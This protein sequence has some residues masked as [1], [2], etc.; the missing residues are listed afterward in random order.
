MCQIKNAFS[1]RFLKV[2]FFF[3]LLYVIIKSYIPC[4]ALIIVR[5][6]AKYPFFK[7]IAWLTVLAYL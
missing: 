7:K 3:S 5:L 4:S 1:Y 2:D 6:K